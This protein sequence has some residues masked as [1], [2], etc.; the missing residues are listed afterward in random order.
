VDTLGPERSRRTVLDTLRTRAHR[1]AGGR[2]G[3]TQSARSSQEEHARQHTRWAAA[4]TAAFT[5]HV[6]VSF[7]PPPAHRVCAP[8]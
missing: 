3:D 8:T 4:L 6:Q 2:R 1:A 7:S 5:H